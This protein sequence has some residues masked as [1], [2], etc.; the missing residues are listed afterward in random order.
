[1]KKHLSL[2]LFVLISAIASAFAQKSVSGTVS[3]ENQNP[4]P[5]AYVM[6]KGT[7]IG[8]VTDIDGK[9]TLA[10]IPE[11]AETLHISFVGMKTQEVSITG[12]EI[13]VQ[14]EQD[15]MQLDELVVVGYGSMKKS[16]L[17]GAVTRM[18]MDDLP[19]QANLN[20]IQ[21]LQGYT[22]GIN[23]Q[24]T[25]GAGAEPNLSVRGQTSLSASDQPLIVLNGIIFN[26]SIS[27]INTNDVETIDILK[28]ASAAAVFGARS[29]NGVLLITTKKGKT[30]KP[31]I[32][33]NAYYG[34]QG[35]TNN[36]MKVMDSEQYALRLVDYYYQQDL[37]TWY[38]TKPTDGTG[39]PV[40]PDITDRTI[41][42]SRL[43]TQEEKD[44]YVAGNSIDWVKEVM[45]VAPVQQYNLNY[46]GQSNKTSY[47]VSGSYT[48][49]EGIMK[50]D[51]FTRLTF[52]ANV[53][54]ELSE[55]LTLG[56]V[57]SYSYRDYSGLSADLE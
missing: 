43:R 46:S 5:G 9:F 21:A 36:P 26:G 47:F 6:V 56:M 52:N 1:M 38:Y 33:F 49:E 15:L 48:N 41:V 40:Y 44:N 22:P 45:H 51:A 31:R 53:E 17:T 18:N 57:S 27:D 24:A 25:G 37:Y 55:W 8:T 3:D 12:G 16:D 50:N 19:P 30:D 35:M 2:T 10:N 23:I 11:D 7:N 28:D 34:V 13:N 14:L 32:S 54:S 42:A 20:I 29:A 39:R 4:I